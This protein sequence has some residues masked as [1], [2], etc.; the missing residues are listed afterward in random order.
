MAGSSISLPA[1]KTQEGK[2]VVQCFFF[3]FCTVSALKL[4]CC[5]EQ[6]INCDVLLLL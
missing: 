3:F 1:V 4:I 6:R 5:I 2:G